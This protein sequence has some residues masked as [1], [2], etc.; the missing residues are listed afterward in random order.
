MWDPPSF[1]GL[2]YWCCIRIKSLYYFFC[3]VL[4]S[5]CK[6][7]IKYYQPRQLVV[8]ITDSYTHFSCVNVVV[9]RVICKY[10]FPLYNLND[11]APHG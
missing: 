7:I 2:L 6:K 1:E 10:H 8:G 5:F 3:F 11:V 4:F 9:V